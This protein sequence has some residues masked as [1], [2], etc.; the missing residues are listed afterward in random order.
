[1]RLKVPTGK[2]DKKALVIFSQHLV[3]CAATVSAMRKNKTRQ[4][5]AFEKLSA[6]G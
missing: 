3:P 6:D 4:N 5:G 2:T 1:L